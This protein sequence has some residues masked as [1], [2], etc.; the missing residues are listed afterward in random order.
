MA[1]HDLQRDKIRYGDFLQTGFQQ[2]PLVHPIF[3]S[4]ETAPIIR[5]RPT[6]AMARNILDCA[7]CFRRAVL[8]FPHGGAVVNATP[9]TPWGRRFA[10]AAAAATTTTN[11]TT[12]TST[13]D[14]PRTL[15]AEPAEPSLVEKR[16]RE[17]LETIVKKHLRHMSDD[18]WLVAQYVE[19]ALARD[20]FDEAL[21]LVQKA[22]RGKQMVVAWNHLIDYQLS[23]QQVK[24]ALK[25]YN[26]VSCPR[27][28][29]IR[30]D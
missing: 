19:K 26:D 29:S 16:S 22:S 8:G 27:L 24:R 17:R 25:I 30:R 5:R 23:K 15:E 11:N 14:A 12:N 10:T 7:V 21:L 20:A 18:P 3:C 4:I 6:F 13:V 2:P 9:F 1:R 28:S